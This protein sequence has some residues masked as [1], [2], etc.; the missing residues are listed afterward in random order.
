MHSR[1]WE[2]AY[3]IE[4]IILIDDCEEAGAII[5]ERK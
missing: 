2:N 1:I 5:Y 4:A 3:R